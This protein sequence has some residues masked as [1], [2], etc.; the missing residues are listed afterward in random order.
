MEIWM[1]ILYNYKLYKLTMK[2][3]VY[4]YVSIFVNRKMFFIVGL[5]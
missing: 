2:I 3:Y 1:Y 4:K 5:K